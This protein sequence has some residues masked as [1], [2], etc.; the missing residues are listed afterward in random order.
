[1]KLENHIVKR[2][3]T[4]ESLWTEMIID[5]AA[6]QGIDLLKDIDAAENYVSMYELLSNKDNKTY[7]VTKSVTEKLNLFDTKRCLDIEGI[8]LTLRRHLYYMI[9]GPAF[10]YLRKMA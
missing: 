2:L 1:M 10:G 4:D 7:Y 3:L 6:G 5:Q 9:L 8:F